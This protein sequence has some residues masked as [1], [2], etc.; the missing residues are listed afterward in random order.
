VGIRGANLNSSLERLF[1]STEVCLENEVAFCKLALRSRLWRS[2][3]EHEKA[4][5]EDASVFVV[6]QL[7]R[8]RYLSL[9]TKASPPLKT[10]AKS[11]APS[12]RTG[13]DMCSSS[14]AAAGGLVGARAMPARSARFTV[15]VY[16]DFE[17][18][19]AKG[20]L[21]GG[22]TSAGVCCDTAVA[23]RPR[24]S[25]PPS[26]VIGGAGRGG[27]GP[28]AAAAAAEAA[29]AAEGDLN[30]ALRLR[31]TR[32]VCSVT[33]SLAISGDGGRHLRWWRYTFRG[34]DGSTSQLVPANLRE[35]LLPSAAFLPTSPM[36][37]LQW[38]RKL[39]RASGSLLTLCVKGVWWGWLGSRS[40]YSELEFRIPAQIKVIVSWLQ[41]LSSFRY[42]KFPTP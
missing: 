3:L 35:A 40:A 16:G 31:S 33:S 12:A 7:C 39:A 20:G 11:C 37:G 22:P 13:D 6:P 34:G 36:L 32:A 41:G 5:L 29:L 8:A 25:L 10:T 15:D 24:S 9:D 26:L 38:V 4:P 17:R 19:A 2:L 42:S 28:R 21:T 18:L 30:C 27:G 23:G 14:M 1:A